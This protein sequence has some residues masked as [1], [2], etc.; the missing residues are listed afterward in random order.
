MK[1]YLD[2]LNFITIMWWLLAFVILFFYQKSCGS[3][4]RISDNIGITLIDMLALAGYAQL[5]RIQFIPKLLYKKKLLQFTMVLLVSIVLFANMIL[6]LQWCWFIL[7]GTAQM[8]PVSNLLTDFFYQFFNVYVVVIFGCLSTIAI[9][10]LGDQLMSQTHNAQLQKEKAQT[11]LRF[12]KAQINP[13]F[14]FNSINSIFA[15]IDKSNVQAREIVLKFSDMLRYQLYECNI[16]FIN[17]EKELA[18]LNNYVELQRLRKEED[19]DVLVETKGDMHGFEIA[20]ILLVPFIENAFKFASSHEAKKNYLRIAL[21]RQ[22]G[23]FSFN[24]INTKDSITSRNLLEE[25]GIGISNVKRRLELIYH[26]RHE[27]DIRND[28]DVFEVNLKIKIA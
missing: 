6:L 21:E 10:V 19:L 17:F 24:C 8:L 13:H 5:I 1:S 3:I 22:N 7:K 2:R 11:E 16:D 25:G 4:N 15:H 26:N 27:L 12:L 14:L 18:Y 28:D 23:Y 9:Q 20:P